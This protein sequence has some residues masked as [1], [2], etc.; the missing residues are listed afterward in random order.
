M[1]RLPIRLRLTIVFAAAL[2]LVLTGTGSLL[3]LRMSSTL[4]AALDQSLRTRVAD[5]AALLRQS[6][7]GLRESG[8]QLQE[9]TVAQVIDTNGRIVDATREAPVR[10]LLDR[11]AR[12]AA[13]RSR[14]FLDRPN[15][16]LLALPVQAQ[17]R[18][19]LIVVGISTESRAEA[20]AALRNEL[21]LGGPATL[22][23]VSL[24]AYALAH[25]S[26]RPIESMRRR[27]A[28]ISG[29]HPGE[30]LPIP[31]AR[32][33][34]A[35]LGTTLNEM[36][37]RLELALDRERRF[38]TDASHELR[39]PLALLKGEI[40]LALEDDQNA[41]ELRAALRSAGAETDRLVRLAEDLLLLARADRGALPL[42]REQ[43]E[44][45]DLLERIATRFELR[46]RES[47]RRVEVATAGASIE[48]DPL[49]LEQALSNLLDNALRHGDGTVTLRAETR[50]NTVKLHVADEGP[51]MPQTLREHAFEPFRRGSDLRGE[52]SGLGLA[53]VSA[54]AHAHGGTVE[55]QDRERG[56]T[57]I[58]IELPRPHPTPGVTK[59]EWQRAAATG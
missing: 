14:R 46:A 4:S 41:D 21:F 11:S 56:G 2:G 33:E 38:V 40:E 30:R 44:A 49:R 25:A 54:I 20:L 57:D 12:A 39:T 18:R 50:G 29:D 16:R 51:G 9:G 59:I 31:P 26:L 58:S 24:L 52:G 5:L 28:A 13:M 15:E 55:L 22:L 43:I 32:D 48:G 53:I 27:A 35:L 1:N 36:L 3:Y 10:P 6:D 17:D 8:Q 19:L 37:A 45:D 23:V 42:R 47:G 34:V 7:S